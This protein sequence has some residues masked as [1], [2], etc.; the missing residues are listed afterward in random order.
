[1]INMNDKTE[2]AKIYAVVTQG[3]V[4]ILVLIGIG[5][6]IGYKIDKD[7]SWPIILAVIGG[8]CGIVSLI[9]MLFKLNVGGDKNGRD[10]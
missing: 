10:S 2:L 7:S 3:F 8:L 4:T 1:M 5:F 9:T 6:F